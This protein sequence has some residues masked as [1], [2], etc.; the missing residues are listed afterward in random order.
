MQ[1]KFQMCFKN[2]LA[3]D[4]SFQDVSALVEIYKDYFLLI[5]VSKY[6]AF[7]KKT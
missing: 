2:N 7:G 5:Q 4:T 3:I 6:K 1:F